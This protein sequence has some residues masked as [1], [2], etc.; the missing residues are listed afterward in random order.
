MKVEES[1][2]LIDAILPDG[3]PDADARRRLEMRLGQMVLSPESR[4]WLLRAIVRRDDR[5]VVGIINFHGVPNDAGQAEL[6]YTIFEPYRRLGYAS[7][8]ASAMMS[9]ARQMHDITDFIVSISPNNEPS[10]R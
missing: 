10:L 2:A 3:W 1:A 6:G 9:W 5:H 7:E 4:E 8:A